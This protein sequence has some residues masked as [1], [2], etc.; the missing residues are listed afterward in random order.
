MVT[1]MF[2]VFE[3]GGKQYRVSENDLITVERLPA[4][5]GK[6]VAFSEVLMVGGEGAPKRGR[7]LCARRA[8]RRGSG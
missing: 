7:A 6:T 2:A 3:T 4:E 1:T 8:H 5:K